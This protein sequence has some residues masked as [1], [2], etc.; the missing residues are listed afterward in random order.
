MENRE[1]TL[2]FLDS[3]GISY[4]MVEHPVCHTIEDMEEAG[5]TAHGNV[6][7]NFF[8]RDAKGKRHFVITV[9]KD[10]SVDVQAIAKQIGSTRLSFGSEDRLMKH[11]QIV[12]GQVGPLAAI[13]NP[14]NTV[15]FIFDKDIKNEKNLGIHPNDNTATLFLS[16]D[17][18]LKVLKK[19]GH[20]FDIQYISI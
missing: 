11:L 3:M 18:V 8:V 15:E 10:K 13:N 9:P 4:K 7:K 12:P 19:T 5:I 6:Y 1:K 14:D 17:D 16:F 2:K 20:D